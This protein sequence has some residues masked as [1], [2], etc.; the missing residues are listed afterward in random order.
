MAT[1]KV[2]HKDVDPIIARFKEL[3]VDGSGVLTAEDLS[4]FKEEVTTRLSVA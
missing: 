3:D 1:G 4:G 2:T